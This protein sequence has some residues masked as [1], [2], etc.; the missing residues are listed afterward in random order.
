MSRTNQK[1]AKPK[2]ASARCEG[3]VL[4]LTLSGGALNG[5]TV[6]VPAR[7]LKSLAA[8]SDEQLARVEVVSSGNVIVW[9]EADADFAVPGLLE[10]IVGVQSLRSHLENIQGMTSQ[11]K[12]ASSRAN[13][14]RGGRP[15]KRVAEETALT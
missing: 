1:N 12:A 7:E 13:G 14:A 11:A 2:V 5:A 6:S 10:R 8:L 9:R 4:Q 15:R 3:G